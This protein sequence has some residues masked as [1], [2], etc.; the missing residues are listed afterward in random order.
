MPSYKPCPRIH[1]LQQLLKVYW[2]FH[3]KVFFSSSCDMTVDLYFLLLLLFGDQS[4]YKISV[5]PNI[6]ALLYPAQAVSHWVLT[7][8]AQVQSQASLCWNF[9][10]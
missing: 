2:S 6:S 4:S 9:C 8:K 7:M 5:V 3:I 10:G 1:T